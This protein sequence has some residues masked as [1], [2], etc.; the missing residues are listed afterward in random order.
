VDRLVFLAHRFSPCARR[1]SG[2]LVGVGIVMIFPPGLNQ[3]TGPTPR[4]GGASS[5]ARLKP[6]AAISA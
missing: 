4:I 3:P 6:M 5:L 1:R 2:T